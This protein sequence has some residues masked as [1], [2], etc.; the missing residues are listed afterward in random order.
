[1][2]YDTLLRGYQR[3]E[4]FIALLPHIGG[5]RTDGE[6]DILPNPARVAVAGQNFRPVAMSYAS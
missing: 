2:I 5:R 3:C 1:M 4:P 6:R